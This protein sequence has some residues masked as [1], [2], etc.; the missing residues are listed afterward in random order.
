[1]RGT[2]KERE[3]GKGPYSVPLFAPLSPLL[4]S[5]PP[6]SVCLSFLLSSPPP[7]SLSLSLR[8]GILIQ[9]PNQLPWPLPEGAIQQQSQA[10]QQVIATSPSPGPLLVAIELG[11]S[12]G[13]LTPRLQAES[14]TIPAEPSS[15]RPPQSSHLPSGT[16]SQAARI[17]HPSHQLDPAT[18]P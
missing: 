2:R 3:R 13:L 11:H 17:E 10:G 14:T 7:L 8:S 18:A 4:S 12:S 16:P 1:M 6:L 15:P 9:D 5:L